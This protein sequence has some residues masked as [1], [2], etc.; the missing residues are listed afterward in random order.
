[1]LVPVAED[2]ST[3]K[4]DRFG[5][6]KLTAVEREGYS[7]EKQ[8]SLH[9][10]MEE[11]EGESSKEKQEEEKETVAVPK[12][13]QCGFCNELLDAAILLPCCVAAACD[14]CARNSLIEQDHVCKLC[15]EADISPNDLIPN[16]LL[17]KKVA[18]FRGTTGN[19]IKKVEARAPLAPLPN[20]VL[21]AETMLK[22]QKEQEELN[23]REEE[24]KLEQR[25]LEEALLAKLMSSEQ[26]ESASASEEQLANDPAEEETTGVSLMESK[27]ENEEKGESALHESEEAPSSPAGPASSPPGEPDS[28]TVLTEIAADPSAASEGSAK[29]TS[30][31]SYS[32]PSMA[33]AVPGGSVSG[34]VATVPFY[35]SLYDYSQPPPG[36]PAATI[37]T[38]FP[39]YGQYDGWGRGDRRRRRSRSRSRDRDRDRYSRD[40]EMDRL[41]YNNWEHHQ[42]KHGGM[43]RSRT[44]WRDG[45]DRSGER[46]GPRSRSRSKGR[47]SRERR[48]SKSREKRDRSSKSMERSSKSM[49]RSSFSEMERFDKFEGMSEEEKARLVR[50]KAEAELLANT[51]PHSKGPSV[52]K[53]EEARQKLKDLISKNKERTREVKEK[54][55][56]PRKEPK[57][58]KDKEKKTK[59][60]KVKEEGHFEQEKVREKRERER[61]RAE[62]EKESD[63]DW[64]CGDEHC[65]FVNFKR[66]IECKK[67]QRPQPDVPVFWDLPG[68]PERKPSKSRGTESWDDGKE[69]RIKGASLPPEDE[70]VCA[71]PEMDIVLKFDSEEGRSS[72]GSR[73][74]R[75]GSRN[76]HVTSF[77]DDIRDNFEPEPA[78]ENLLEDNIGEERRV[79][80]QPGNDA[81]NVMIESKS[82]TERANSNEH[83]HEIDEKNTSAASKIESEK[84]FE[85]ISSQAN[86]G[87]ST[88]EEKDNLKDGAVRKNE[89]ERRKENQS[90]NEV[91]EEF[92]DQSKSGSGSA[93]DASK[94]H[95]W[96]DLGRRSDEFE[97]HL[98]I[99]DAEFVDT[100][101]AEYRSS[102]PSWA[103]CKKF[104]YPGGGEE[105]AM[106]VRKRMEDEIKRD[107][108]EPT[109]TP[110]SEIIKGR[111]KSGEER[112]EEDQVKMR[113]GE[114]GLWKERPYRRSSK[115]D[116]VEV[117]ERERRE[118]SST[119]EGERERREV[120]QRER[121]RKDRDRNNRMREEDEERKRRAKLEDA[122]ESQEKWALRAAKKEREMKEKKK[123][124]EKKLAEEELNRRRRREEEDINRRQE[125]LRQE[126]KILD[127]EKKAIERKRASDERRRGNQE[128]SKKRTRSGSGESSGSKKKVVGD[129][130]YLC[131]YISNC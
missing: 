40:R 83:L 60:H 115:D 65:R 8:E 73:S 52:D 127:A 77:L 55:K 47:K 12:E 42:R 96:N 62:R 14:E 7:Q 130:R 111:R 1:M 98:D 19:Q 5:G 67:C 113:A 86:M 89:E 66:N 90:N 26:E 31:T 74:S 39:P 36:Y 45:R 100:V 93:F 116:L 17:R 24:A 33:P 106:S 10:L 121:D 124:E 92:E 56:K 119:S 125:M 79:Y 114:A 49:E 69:G 11:K 103:D 82:A 87:N 15:E 84:S 101:K 4:V 110:K 105:K 63:G 27:E 48:R 72:R 118:G 78:K 95:K 126:K 99:N 108:A 123:L 81:D 91:K 44:E 22:L 61:E 43:R 117:F 34:Y 64:H 104:K 102:S 50:A 51:E 20:A 107:D 53:K 54:D 13:L 30:S 21:P 129:L 58:K 80:L 97:L 35:P 16:P 23:K 3:A 109:V 37:Y 18:A 122:R 68:S 2:T 46:R 128:E 85:T 25:R 131:I 29:D 112:A 76:G 75:P 41:G 57:E 94:K 71:S 6:L 38:N 120:R 32:I 28:S 88:E 9:W 59:K 70:H